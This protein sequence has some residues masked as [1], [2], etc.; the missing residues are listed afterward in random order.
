MLGCSEA[1]ILSLLAWR[2]WAVRAWGAFAVPILDVQ[3]CVYAQRLG[4]ALGWAWRAMLS[5][6]GGAAV[7]MERR[8]KDGCA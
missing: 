6:R 7:R 3:G 8:G 1:R 5:G 4:Y 2:A